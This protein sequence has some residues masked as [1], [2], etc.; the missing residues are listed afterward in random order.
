MKTKMKQLENIKKSLG[1]QSMMNERKNKKWIVGEKI[2]NIS[3]KVKKCI[4]LESLWENIKC[5][6]VLRSS[7]SN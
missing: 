7:K 5:R 6:K 3:Q 2:N 1:N 4:S